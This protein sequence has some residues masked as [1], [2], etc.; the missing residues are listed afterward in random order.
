[1]IDIMLPPLLYAILLG[2]GLYVFGS[3]CGSCIDTSSEVDDTVNST[4]TGTSSEVDNTVTREDAKEDVDKYDEE[5]IAKEYTSPKFQAKLQKAT[6]EENDTVNS[7][8]IDSSFGIHNFKTK[9]AGKWKVICEIWNDFHKSFVK[10]FYAIS[11]VLALAV[12]LLGDFSLLYISL[13]AL[14]TIFFIEVLSS[15]LVGI[16]IQA[17]KK[18]EGFGKDVEKWRNRLYIVFGVVFWLSVAAEFNSLIKTLL[19]KSSCLFWD[20]PIFFSFVSNAKSMYLTLYLISSSTYQSVVIRQTISLH[21]L[22]Y[23][24]HHMHFIGIILSILG[25]YN[26]E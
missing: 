19:S 23:W 22:L 20:V 26:Y 1:M 9:H 10:E 7:T 21:C 5:A 25:I 15:K 17:A 6:T 3:Y 18:Y 12:S 24:D 13:Y 16:R 14:I 4:S 2:L 8:S 11:S